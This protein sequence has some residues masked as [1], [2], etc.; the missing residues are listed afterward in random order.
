MEDFSVFHSLR[1]VG[2]SERESTEHRI[3]RQETEDGSAGPAR[4]RSRTLLTQL[5]HWL[6]CHSEAMFEITTTHKCLSFLFCVSLFPPAVAHPHHVMCMLRMHVSPEVPV[7]WYTPWREEAVDEDYDV[8]VL[9]GE[10][11]AGG[12]PRLE[13]L[14][15]A[16]AHCREL[17][18]LAV[19]GHDWAWPAGE[20]LVELKLGLAGD[21][22]FLRRGRP[23]EDVVDVEACVRRWGESEEGCLW[24]GVGADE[25][26]G[27]ISSRRAERA[28][29][30]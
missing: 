14:V 16:A 29:R 30:R 8:A 24:L 20:G 22:R 7:R 11:K 19:L 18:L 13:V 5:G 10:A 9:A 17:L 21:G 3:I 2:R 4:P 15:P 6:L 12:G 26:V 28:E 23:E 25:E 27:S 1:S